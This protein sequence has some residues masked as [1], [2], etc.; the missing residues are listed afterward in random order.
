MSFPTIA[1]FEDRNFVGICHY[2][3]VDVKYVVS[4]PAELSGNVASAVVLT[5]GAS[6][7]RV[8]LE[9]DGGVLSDQ[10]KVEG[11]DQYSDAQAT[12]PIAKDR[13]ALMPNL[14]KLKGQR[15]LVVATTRNGDQLLMGRKETPCMVRVVNRTTGDGDQMETDR[16]EYRIVMSL[17]RR[18]P[19]PFYQG[20]IPDPTPVGCPTLEEQ[21]AGETGADLLDLMS[22]TQITEWLTAYGLET[23]DGVKDPTPA[24]PD[25]ELVDPTP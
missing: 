17:V 1:R 22:P 18:L 13:L 3:V 19:V 7:S 11:G 4:V 8:Y 2:D 16:N 5:D 10:W 24:A 21:M 25:G 14:W 15:Y 9:D 23:F 20:T 12:G 6:W